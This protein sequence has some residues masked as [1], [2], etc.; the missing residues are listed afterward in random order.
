MSEAT[1]DSMRGLSV[2]WSLSG[3]DEALAQQLRDYVA[4]P[5]WA[6]FSGMPGLAFKTWRMRAGEWFE[7]T[8]VFTSAQERTRFQ[9]TFTAGAATAPVSEFVG[10][11]PELIEPFEVLA[12]AQGAAPSPSPSLSAR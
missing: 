7:G 12:V 10:V 1:G 2:R 9:E 11:G 8:Y 4:G 6:K 5:S 3:T